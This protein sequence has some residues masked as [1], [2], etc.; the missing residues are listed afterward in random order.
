[1]SRD[2]LVELATDSRRR[3]FILG[4]RLRRNKGAP[5][6]ARARAR[7]L[8]ARPDKKVGHHLHDELEPTGAERHS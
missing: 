5:H 4:V 7:I 3:R 2:N 6:P 8:I 1:V